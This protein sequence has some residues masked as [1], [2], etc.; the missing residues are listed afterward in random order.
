MQLKFFSSIFA[1]QKQTNGDQD[2][3]LFTLTG[4]LNSIAT[5]VVKDTALTQL[6]FKVSIPAEV[7]EIG[8]VL[9]DECGVD[10]L[11]DV[12]DNTNGV[13][14]HKRDLKEYGIYVDVNFGTELETITTF[15]GILRSVSFTHSTKSTNDGLVE[16]ACCTLEILKNYDKDSDFEMNPYVKYKEVEP[17]S[18]KKVLIPMVLTAEQIDTNPVDMTEI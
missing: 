13:W 17:T 3:S 1:F 18:G 15:K 7:R 9:T 11:K 6:K 2:M 4:I 12:T 10:Q 14:S 8:R 5:V 16:N